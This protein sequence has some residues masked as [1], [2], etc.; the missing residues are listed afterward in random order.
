MMVSFTTGVCLNVIL[1]PPPLGHVGTVVREKS[2]APTV[3]DEGI[4]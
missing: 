4:L 3:P 1:N 2:S